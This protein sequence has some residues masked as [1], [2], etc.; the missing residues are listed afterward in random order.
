MSFC[1][2]GNGLRVQRGPARRAPA[3]PGRGDAVAGTLG[4]EP[5]LEVGDHAE[6]MEHEFAGGRGGIEAFLEADEVDAAGLD[7]GDDYEE[8]AQGASESVE[9]GHAQPVSGSG[10]VDEL[11]EPGAV[12]ALSGGD[13]GEDTDGASSPRRRALH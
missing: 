2:A 9:A 3:F 7:V 6:H 12:R 8:F 13:V 11:G 1:A 4:D 10:V 5:L